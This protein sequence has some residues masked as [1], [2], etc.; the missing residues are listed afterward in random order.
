MGAAL[1]RT[2]GAARLD[3]SRTEALIVDDS[4]PS[5]QITV[6]ILMGLRLKSQQTCE[7]AKEARKLVVRKRFDLLII[8]L[9]M[10]DE[11]GLELARF[12]RWSF[13]KPNFATPILMLSGCPSDAK[14]REARDAGAARGYARGHVLVRPHPSGFPRRGARHRHLL[15]DGRGDEGAGPCARHLRHLA[16]AHAC[17]D[18]ADPR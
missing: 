13:D 4:G 7:C 17:R 14:T 18:G 6:Q 1:A 5:L 12:V 2:N 8:D 11:D 15:V 9:E 10:P 16:V 3:L